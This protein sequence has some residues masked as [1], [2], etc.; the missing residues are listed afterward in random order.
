VKKGTPNNKESVPLEHYRAR[1]ASTPA[2]AIAARCRI[3]FDAP[4]SSF[5]FAVLNQPLRAAWPDFALT[6]MDATT[7][8]PALYGAAAQILLLRHLIEGSSAPSGGKFLSYRELPW[9][10]VYDGNFQGRCVRR[11]ARMFGSRLGDFARAVQRLGGV[12]FDNVKPD[13]VK[14]VKID[15]EPVTGATTENESWE[16]LFLS[17][18][19]IRLIIH[20]GDEEFPATAQFLFSDNVA[21]AFTAEDLAVVGDLVIAALAFNG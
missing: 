16:I 20:A 4:T 3:P 6:P 19:K 17:D 21:L 13:D 9:G 10:E 8:P 11:L 1:Y 5:T 14:D 2:E 12:K 18:T 7:C 15:A